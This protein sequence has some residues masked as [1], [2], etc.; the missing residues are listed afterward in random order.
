MH[1]VYLEYFKSKCQI[2][3]SLYK[4]KSLC[5]ISISTA[6]RPKTTSNVSNGHAGHFN[7]SMRLSKAVCQNI[8][9]CRKPH[10]HTES[11]QDFRIP[12]NTSQERDSLTSSTWSRAVRA[13]HTP[14][15]LR[16]LL[17][18]RQSVLPHHTRVP[19]LEK[20]LSAKNQLVRMLSAAWTVQNLKPLFIMRST[21]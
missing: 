1:F 20:D 8:M 6:E 4:K 21:W 15:I 5:K 9:S 17:G 19:S 3:I 2:T 11:L 13:H 7:I 12:W 16:F 18:A 14:A 10:A